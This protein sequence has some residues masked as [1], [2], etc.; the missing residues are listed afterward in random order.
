MVITKVNC[1]RA[2]P[3]CLTCLNSFNFPISQ[4]IYVVSTTIVPI[5]QEGKTEVK[6]CPEITQLVN[7]RGEMQTQAVRL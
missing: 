5:F 6:H 2:S 4:Q 3:K 7:G 1:A